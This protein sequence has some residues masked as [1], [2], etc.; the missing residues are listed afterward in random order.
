VLH[1]LWGLT[2]A[3]PPIG[4]SVYS[5]HSVEL[6][7]VYILTSITIPL[8]IKL[9]TR[10]KLALNIS[11]ESSFVSFLKLPYVGDATT[12]FSAMISKEL[13]SIP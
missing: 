5:G 2:Y 10:Y 4:V 9:T 7:K 3:Y 1:A 13:W 11:N 8:L 12:V 6:Q